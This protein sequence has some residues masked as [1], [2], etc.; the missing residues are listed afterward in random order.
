MGRKPGNKTTTI[1][2]G[3]VRNFKPKQIV[4]KGKTLDMFN[5]ER[6]RRELGDSS[7][8][9]QIIGDYFR[10]YTPPGFGFKPKD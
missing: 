1:I 5:H 2:N 10:N 8:G 3:V 4:L 9:A 7:L 6:D